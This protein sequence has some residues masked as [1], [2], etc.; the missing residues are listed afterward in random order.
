MKEKEFRQLLDDA[1][2]IDIFYTHLAIKNLNPLDTN[3]KRK[4]SIKELKFSELP[5]EYD[6]DKIF[7]YI[8]EYLKKRKLDTDNHLVFLK[9]SSGYRLIQVNESMSLLNISF[10]FEDL[11]VLSFGSGHYIITR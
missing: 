4:Y 6:I 11:K 2:E 5:L 1:Y 7:D 8:V 10:S 9:P 3:H